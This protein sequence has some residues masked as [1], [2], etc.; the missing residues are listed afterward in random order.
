MERLYDGKLED[1]LIEQLPETT[2]ADSLKQLIYNEGIETGNV[3]QIAAAMMTSM[4]ILPDPIEDFT[5]QGIP[6]NVTEGDIGTYVRDFYKEC[7]FE[8][9]ESFGWEERR[10]AGEGKYTRG[11]V[12]L[13]VNV[14]LDPFVEELYVTVRKLP[15]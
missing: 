10:K 3:R 1:Y 8:M 15:Y 2:P 12:N 7:G 5:I 4:S 6:D 14:T 11:D 9:D 13:S